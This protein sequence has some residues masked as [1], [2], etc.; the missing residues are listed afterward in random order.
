M[1]DT[2]HWMAQASGAIMG[3]CL[4]EQKLQIDLLDARAGLLRNYDPVNVD[5]AEGRESLDVLD[6]LPKKS[7]ASVRLARL[8]IEVS[9]QEGLVERF[10]TDNALLQNS[11]TRFTS[12]DRPTVAGQDRL[13]ARIL[14]LT[15][16]TSLQSVMA[17][18]DV[19][20]RTL[21]PAGGT[22]E[23]QLISHARLLVSVLPEI[24]RLL[25]TIR[26]L[27][28]DDEVVA[29]QSVL[30]EESRARAATIQHLQLAVAITVILLM[31][32][33]LA[34]ILVQRLRTR[35]LKGQAANGRLSAAIAIPLIDT[36]GGDFV[37]RVH[38][39]VDRLALHIGAKRLQLIIPGVPSFSHFSWPDGNLDPRW[40]RKLV[41]AADA[42]AVWHG[43]QIIAS[44]GDGNI[45]PTLDLAM[46]DAGISNL[47]L[48]RT[49]GPFGVVIGF[50]PPC[51]TSAQRRDHVAGVS[52][53]V[54]AIAHGARRE[55]LQLERDRLERRLAR[56]RR[57][58]TIGAMA[59]G[60]AHNFNNIIGA[61]GGFAE[62]GQERTRQG[63][64]AR[65][66]FEE[67]Q[68]A[69]ARARDLVDDIL[70]FAKQGRANKRPIRL[71][72][73]L[74]QAVRLL[75]AS[76]RHETTFEVAPTDNCLRVL[77]AGSELQQVFLN[78][79]NN[80]A[81]A[82]G[83]RP[84]IIA[85]RRAHLSDERHMS[86]GGLD[87]GDYIV[88][89]MSDSGPGI[90]A[91]AYPR[92]FEPF[93][94]TRAGGTGLGLSTAWEIVQDHGGTIDVENVPSGGARFAVWLP[95]L[96]ADADTPIIGDGAQIL[97]LCEAAA[98]SHEEEVL[99]ELG[100]E[101]LGFPLSIDVKTLRDV[102]IECDGVLIATQEPAQITGMLLELKTVLA[103]RPLFLAV[104]EGAVAET[105][106]PC[107]RLNYPIEIAT[108]SALLS[109]GK[110]ASRP[111]ETVE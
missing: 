96:S 87:Q 1:N 27:R 46:E 12:N 84:I 20:A 56:A 53:A 59:S 29:L 4:S 11:L 35:E 97:L 108:L 21:L 3:F 61:I 94:T 70:S 58:E 103:D 81:Q 67:I 104:P 77:G 14:Q 43:C 64:S 90:P 52:S 102:I 106:I 10:K 22:P 44:R 79:L 36:G 37:S 54:V 30:H 47:V 101:P 51:R 71:P 13:S 109:G 39:A 50:E 75:S 92:L 105:D 73:V 91:T 28:I 2:R 78:I 7:E 60:V 6:R 41:D 66:N 57:M 5:L 100:Y 33:V 74:T 65:H 99:A 23:A 38:E 24:D 72:D 45:H 83:G 82:S 34:L 69:V 48:L 93:F 68:N 85:T 26:S 86:H 31:G 110:P 55:V 80:A 98:L 25:H 76:S 49:A 107:F 32:S 88:V 62:M 89:S 17:A 63:T 42:D 9:R 8:K 15:L 19:L 18:K 95:E 16:D 111:V 40:L